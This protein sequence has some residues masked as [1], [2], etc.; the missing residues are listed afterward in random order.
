[1]SNKYDWENLDVI[2]INREPPHNTLIPYPDLNSSLNGNFE[3]SSYFIS[4]NGNW[5][6]N[7]V[8]KPA[9]RPVDFYKLDFDVSQW[10][11]IPVPS[12]WQM[13][14]YGIPIYTNIRYPFSVKLENIPSIDHEYNP[15]GSYRRIFEL[16]MEWKSREI[17]IHFRG[18][19][20]AFYLWING[21]KVGYSQG[22]MEPAEFNI[23]NFLQLGENIIAVE[24]YR[25]S[26][27]SYLEDQ[28]MWRFSG[29]F[30][31]VYLLSTPKIHIRDFYARCEL[32]KE[33]KN[34]IL[35]LR[36]KIRNYDVEEAISYRI[37]CLLFNDKKKIVDS[38]PTMKS[39][40]KIKKNQEIVLE[41]QAEVKNPIKWTAET[42]YLYDLILKLK[43]ANENI[44]EVQQCKFGFRVV[45][46]KEDG[47]L[48]L[49]GKSII[50]KGVNRHEHDPDHGRA[51]PYKTMIQDI[52]ILKQNNINAV[53]TS[54]YPNHPKWYELCDK[55]GIYVLDEC[56]LESHGLREILP[57]SDSNWTKAC[58]DRIVRM[59]ER[60]KNHPSIIIWSLGNESGIGDNFK[61][62]KEAAI[63]IDSTRPIHYEG[64]Y[65]QEVSDLVS[66]MY[67]SP[68]QLERFIRKR[69]YGTIGK[70][71]TFKE[72]L[73][74]P[75]V[76]CEYAHAMGN[77]LG[78]FQEFMDIFEKYP[79]AIGGFIW[80]YIDQGLRKLS[81]NGKEFW[82]Y[83]GDFG[84][85][86][87]DKN[88][89]INGILMPDR[90]PNPSLY[91]VKKVYQ[92]IKVYPINLLEGKVKI[93][94]K[95]QFISLDFVE[96]TWKLTINGLE[97]QRGLLNYLKAEPGEIIEVNIP[98]KKPE[99]KSN[100]EYLLKVSFSLIQ[101]SLWAKKGYIL[102][103]DQFQIPFNV[104]ERAEIDIDS[105]DKIEIEESN[106]IFLIKGKTFKV[107]LGK[108]SGT[109]DFLSFNNTDLILDPL[110]PNFWRA[111]TDNDLGIIDFSDKSAP[112]YD[113][114]WKEASATRRLL[115]ITYEKI[116]SY[117]IRIVVLFKIL[118]N[119]NTLN[120]TYTFYGN[121]DIFIENEFI[122]D[123]DMV[124]FGMQAKIPKNF[125]QMTWYGR[126]PH[127]TMLDRKTGGAIGIYS[128]V[129]DYLIHPY[130][131]PQENGNRTDVRWVAFTDKNQ[132]GLLVSDIGKTYLNISAWPYSMEDLEKATHNHELPQCDYITINIDYK[133]QGVGGDI[134]ALAVLHS[135]YKLKKKVLYK[136][137]F[138]IRPISKDIG[139]LSSI[140]RKI[141]PKI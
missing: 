66:F 1:M 111:P 80:D 116:N 117:V 92:N 17:F 110:V 96:I 20:S 30:R 62:M 64:D 100:A 115:K 137:S 131:R 10:N 99:V 95:Y 51:V 72:N 61:K 88:Y 103:W 29:I 45:E 130:I 134:P 43:N 50:L 70:T 7:W 139:D 8:K 138:R 65:L 75:Y 42:P 2:N 33:Y 135:K 57:N 101:N 121:G 79:N 6:F 59:V 77:S 81:E 34:A 129:V 67:L 69:K 55:Y 127:E 37:E 114:R 105:M 13:H 94:N 58:I 112:S 16:P 113:K 91:E 28:D 18:V 133:Q 122:P 47:G 123:I 98:F 76:L 140:A 35:K 14:G 60:D 63:Q 78:N 3:G 56:N 25:W 119:E 97:L 15:V 49:N 44:I 12:N 120:I 108:N 31:D 24:V 125:N 84:D 19:K 109:I 22:S 132:S 136:Y 124:K 32:D 40:F 39:T 82:A 73:V 89:C 71:F 118:N 23:T 52:E 5:K 4:L 104:P 128:D 107:R 27:G 53:R 86:P 41:L 106:N 126:G 26:D 68:K 36:I 90:K 83:G 141:P 48:Y 38:D 21:E 54:H 11:E 87:N 85:E 102:A 9:D 46:I 74:K 93:H